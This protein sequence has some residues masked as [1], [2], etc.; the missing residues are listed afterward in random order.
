M[1]CPNCNPPTE[2][3]KYETKKLVDVIS[4]VKLGYSDFEKDMANVSSTGLAVSEKTFTKKK[5]RKKRSKKVN[6]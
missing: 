6:K 1:Y 3:E 4:D 2:K 5:P